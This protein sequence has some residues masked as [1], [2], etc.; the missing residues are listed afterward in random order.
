MNKYI[1]DES[2]GLWYERQGDYYF[3]CL[4]LPTEEVEV[5]DYLMSN[6]TAD[7]DEDTE[8]APIGRYGRLRE[9]FLREYHHGTYT[10]MLLTGRLEPHLRRIDSKAQEQADR[11]VVNLMRENGVDEAVKARDQLGWVQAV[12]SFKSM[13][14]EWV[15]AEIVYR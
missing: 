11:I 8:L 5:T 13:A 4:S 15:L 14:E 2:N 9:R 12:N 3:P 7:R 1:F 10:S 6:L